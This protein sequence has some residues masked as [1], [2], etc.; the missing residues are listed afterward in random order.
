M[1]TTPLVGCIALLMIIASNFGGQAGS[2][3][4]KASALEGRNWIGKVANE[5]APHISSLAP[6]KNNDGG[7]ARYIQIIID[8]HI[9][10]GTV[11]ME[12]DAKK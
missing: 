6:P 1:N 7:N 3:Y 9:Y 10:S 11:F 12:I 2:W 5:Y 8:G 4:I